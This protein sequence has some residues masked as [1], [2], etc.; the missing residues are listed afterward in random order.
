VRQLQ[1]AVTHVS[2]ISFPSFN[3]PLSFQDNSVP[4]KKTAKIVDEI[5]ILAYSANK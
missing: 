3:S 5:N 4:R 1:P 2:S